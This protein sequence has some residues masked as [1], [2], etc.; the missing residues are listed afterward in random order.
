LHLAGQPAPHI[1]ETSA[2]RFRADVPITERPRQPLGT[3]EGL[4]S[5]FAVQNVWHRKRDCGGCGS[6]CA[7]VT[8]ASRSHIPAYF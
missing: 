6:E 1:P 3:L 4:V 5:H 8:H 2:G 7:A